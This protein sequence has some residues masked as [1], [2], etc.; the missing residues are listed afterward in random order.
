[1]D[2]TV[3]ARVQFAMTVMFHFLFPAITIGLALIVAVLETLR[4]RTREAL[5]D[6]AAL[7]WTRIFGVTFLMGVATGTVMEFQF[8]TNWARYSAFV[9][10]VFGA[11][12]AAEGV[13]A[14]FL[15]STFLG[16]LLFGRGLVSSAVR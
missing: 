12:L 9:G 14:F 11:P 6:R 7:F 16:I 13:F 8:G 15:E 3:L 4:W 2:P 5:W 1:M 10:D